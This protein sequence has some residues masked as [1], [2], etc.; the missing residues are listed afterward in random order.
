MCVNV[1]PQNAHAYY[2]GSVLPL[3]VLFSGARKEFILTRTLFSRRLKNSCVA[4]FIALLAYDSWASRE[5]IR[6]IG[7][8]PACQQCQVLASHSDLEMGFENCRN[9]PLRKPRLQIILL[10]KTTEE[11]GV[12]D[13]WHYLLKSDLILTHVYFHVTVIYA[14]V[15]DSTKLLLNQDIL[16]TATTTFTH[17]SLNDKKKMAHLRIWTCWLYCGSLSILKRKRQKPVLT[18]C[19]LYGRVHGLQLIWNLCI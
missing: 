15:T 2:V 14:D 6:T 16:T 17:T 18:F 3:P 9:S 10:S 5:N 13:N 4:Y 7:S 12:R 1:Q 8:A 19:S 11:K